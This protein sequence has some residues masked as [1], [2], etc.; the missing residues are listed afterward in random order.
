MFAPYRRVWWGWHSQHFWRP[1]HLPVVWKYLRGLL[2]MQPRRGKKTHQAFDNNK[3][4]KQQIKQLPPQVPIEAWPGKS[5]CGNHLEGKNNRWAEP[6]VWSFNPIPPQSFHFPTTAP[7]RL[8]LWAL[9]SEHHPCTPIRKSLSNGE[10]AQKGSRDTPFGL[11][12][13]LEQS[14]CLAISCENQGRAVSWAGCSYPWIL[15]GWFVLEKEFMASPF[16]SWKQNSPWKT[17]CP[18]AESRVNSEKSSSWE[19]KVHGRPSIA[20]AIILP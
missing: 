8:I 5:V 16:R 2:F 14:V 6:R 13:G 18:D 20:L 7:F 10:D 9:H 11:C 3:R 4:E 1:R 12:L 17:T 19:F 15:A